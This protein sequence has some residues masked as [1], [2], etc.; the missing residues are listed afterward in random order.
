[1]RDCQSSAR[2]R[3]PPVDKSLA[4]QASRPVIDLEAGDDAIGTLPKLLARARIED[5]CLSRH[6][7][8]PPRG[9]ALW[10]GRQRHRELAM[11]GQNRMQDGLFGR[12]IIVNQLRQLRSMA[13][14]RDLGEINLFVAGETL[15]N[16]RSNSQDFDPGPLLPGWRIVHRVR[17][18]RRGERK[19]RHHEDGGLERESSEHRGSLSRASAEHT[20]DTAF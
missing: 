16:R 11:R 2:I 9:I 3:R 19:S 4:C 13:P 18:T 1:M 10:I 12:R 15:M 14:E 17:S 6:E 8:R 20:L 7:E 5:V